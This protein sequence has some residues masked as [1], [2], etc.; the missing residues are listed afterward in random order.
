[1]NLWKCY[2]LS[3][4]LFLLRKRYIRKMSED[5]NML[6][7]ITHMRELVDILKVTDDD[8]K[9]EIMSQLYFWFQ[10]RNCMIIKSMTKID[11]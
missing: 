9:V 1:M 5:G 6:Q 11:N 8:V 7:H 4:K 2:F 10:Y 3:S